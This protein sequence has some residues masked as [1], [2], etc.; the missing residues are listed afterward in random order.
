MS[1][2]L[3]STGINNVTDKHDARCCKFKLDESCRNMPLARQLFDYKKEMVGTEFEHK[4]LTKEESRRDKYRDF[5]GNYVKFHY[6][7]N[8]NDKG[9]IPV[10]KG[11]S[12]KVRCCKKEDEE[13][14]ESEELDDL[15]FEELVLY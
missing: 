7:D 13:L 10:I 15:N 6:L 3:L 4:Y 12:A 11:D 8:Y 1:K 14:I 2:K 9:G 5:Y